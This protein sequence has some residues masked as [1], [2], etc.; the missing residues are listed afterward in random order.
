MGLCVACDCFI[1]LHSSPQAGCALESTMT[2]LIKTRISGWSGSLLLLP[3]TFPSIRI[4]SNESVL[5]VA[6]GGQ[7]IGVSASASVLP[8]NNQD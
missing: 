7:S 8:M 2:L 6:S 3:S 1:I 4:F 5:Q